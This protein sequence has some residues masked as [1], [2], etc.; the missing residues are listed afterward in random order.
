MPFKLSNSFVE[1][2]ARFSSEVISVKDFESLISQIERN[3]N[4]NFYPPS[5]ESNF[6]RILKSVFNPYSFLKDLLR[7]PH[8]ID[9]ILRVTNYSNYLT[10]II[11]KDPELLN[12]ILSS[13]KNELMF[14]EKKLKIEIEN[15]LSLISLFE[16]KINILKRIKRRELL[17]IAILDIIYNEELINITASLSSL[18]KLLSSRLFELCYD[19]VLKKNNVSKR[20]Y[21]F[22]L[23]SLGKLG[24]NELN[25][26]SDIDLILFFDKN[27][28]IEGKDFFD[29]LNQTLLLFIEKASR[30][31]E[32]GYLYRVDFRLRPDGKNS[33]LCRTLNDTIRYYEL[34]GEEWERQMLIKSSFLFGNKKLYDLFRNFINPFVFSPII[35]TSVGNEIKKI[36]NQSIKA[37]ND[38]TDIKISKG[39][40]RDIEFSVQALQLINGAKK[41][42][43]QTGNT[44]NAIHSLSKFKLLNQEEEKV[45]NDA[46]IFFRK[47]EHFLQ[48]M[49]DTQTHSIPAG[50][51]ILIKLADYLKFRNSNALLKEVDDYK[52][53]VHS[54][55]DSI[56]GGESETHDDFT[57]I[58][59]NDLKT[60]R[61]NFVFLSEGKGLHDLKNFDKFTID[62]FEKIR[63]DLIKHL[64]E[65]HNPD[66]LL[67]NIVKVIRSSKFPRLWFD[68]LSNK[69]LM[70]AFIFLAQHCKYCIERMCEDK[71]NR[72]LFLTGNCFTDTDAEFENY[73]SQNLLFVLS[74]Q[75]S[76]NIINRTE[77]SES[78]FRHICKK[79]N[80]AAKEFDKIYNY[81]YFIAL[82]GSTGNHQS[83]LFSDIDILFV[84]DKIPL[85]VDV[86]KQF[87]K[88]LNDIKKELHPFNVDCRLRPE[89][90]S[91]LLVWDLQGNKKYFD[92]RARV[93]EFQSLTKIVFAYGNKNLFDEYIY[94]VIHSC[95]KLD[96]ITIKK[97]ISSIRKLLIHSQFPGSN[98]FHIKKSSGGIIDIEFILQKIILENPEKFWGEKDI[99]KILKQYVNEDEKLT[100]LAFYYFNL[101][102]L[103]IS[104]QIV[105]NNSN[106]IVNEEVLKNKTISIFL[107]NKNLSIEEILKNAKTTSAIYKS[108]FT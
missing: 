30:A 29:L 37:L 38:E 27:K 22:V 104:L 72:D 36:R 100:Q 92:S 6:I 20:V 85:K 70:N 60:A 86:Q 98:S 21:S 43:L 4:I 66:E 74:V 69:K 45:F 15:S 73:S 35:K 79:I 51:E 28:K 48:L 10:D 99:S 80:A 97:E 58:P 63:N 53:K 8:Y 47:I 88:L 26:S 101:K 46:Y 49:N 91:S 40:I 64:K 57:L 59:F 89:G 62:S 23:I 44:L 9:K 68:T 19:E 18:A 67:T 107:S 16:R 52:D 77:L 56:T 103:E 61:K 71:F 3:K 82:L 105:F 31:N 50:G 102:D 25:Y 93:W 75:Y 94:Y 42:E 7:Y 11:V 17:R 78:I 87:A 108:I 1:E 65:S 55:Y 106:S 54:I 84:I 32:E 95:K 34:R 39:G 13:S 2:L 24:G 96:S 76:L 81:N 90:K 12:W 5:S 41:I 33:P 14:N 83:S